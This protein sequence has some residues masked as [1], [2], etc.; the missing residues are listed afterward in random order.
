MELRVFFLD[1]LALVESAARGTH[2]KAQVPQRAGKFG[3]QRTEILL[4]LVVAK[5]EKDIE[6]GVRE[7]QFTSVATESKKAKSLRGS[8]ANTQEFGEYLSN[9]VVGQLAKLSQRVVRACATFKQLP[10]A[11]ATGFTLRPE[12]RHGCI[13]L[14]HFAVRAKTWS[15][16]WTRM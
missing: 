1:A 3:N 14:I 5:K 4:G 9:R 12:Q 8:V 15:K 7:K 11:F 2:T 16:N 13:R 10:D 6:V